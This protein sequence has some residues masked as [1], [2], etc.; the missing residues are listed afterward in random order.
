MCQIMESNN[1]SVEYGHTVKAFCWHLENTKLFEDARIRDIFKW[2]LFLFDIP[3]NCERK[4]I[5]ESLFCFHLFL[6]QLL[7]LFNN[8]FCKH[9]GK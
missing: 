4:K 7:H 2:D 3:D 1:I 8:F 6:I 5:M 9:L